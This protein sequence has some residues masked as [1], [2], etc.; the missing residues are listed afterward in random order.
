MRSFITGVDG[1]IG[2]WLVETLSAAGDE[3]YGLTR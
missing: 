3:I 1:F 2:S